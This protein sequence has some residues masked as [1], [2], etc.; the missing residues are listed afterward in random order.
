MSAVTIAFALAVAT[1]VL[2][3]VLPFFGVH[4]E[5]YTR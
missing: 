2:Q 5:G 1:G 4:I 3:L